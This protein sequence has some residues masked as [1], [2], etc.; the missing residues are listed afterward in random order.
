MGRLLHRVILIRALILWWALSA[1]AWAAV[2]TVTLPG[3]TRAV[4]AA[5]PTGTTTPYISRAT[6]TSAETNAPL[7]FE[8]ALKMR[9]LG[10]LQSRVNRGEHVPPAE[11]AARYQPTAADY[12]A[13]VDWAKAQ[14]FTIVRQDPRHQVLFLRGKVGHIGQ[15]LGVKFSR[16]T[17]EGKEYTSAVDA[18]SVPANIG[19]LLIGINGLQPHL[20]PHR[21]MV[22]QQ[23]HPDA[24]AG[25]TSFLPA[26]IAA[27]YGI[28]PLYN[29]NLT[30]GGQSIAIVIDTFP[31][32]TDL[33]QFW[34]LAS[35]N[36]SISNLI[37]VQAVPGTL[38]SP[39]GEETLD[40][41]WASA[42]APGAKV[43]VYAATSLSNV[44]L[45]QTY[46]A[47]L[48]DA[49]NHPEY[50]LHQMSM[51]FGEGETYATGA[52]LDTDDALFLQLA[53]AGV[54]C[55][56]AS[57]D[58][59][60]TPG[61]SGGGDRSGPTQV[62]SPASDPYVAG[63]G[64]TSL[65]VNP[66]NTISEVVWNNSTGATGG[67]ASAHFARP[68]WQVQASQVGTGT[69]TGTM[70]LVPDIAAA[71]DPDTGAVYFFGG[72]QSVIGGTS[73][74]SPVWAG[75]CALINQARQNAGQPA[76][77]NL[78]PYLYPILNGPDYPANFND[79]QS[80]NNGLRFNSGF[81]AQAGYDEDTGV[82]TPIGSAL[83]QSLIG[84]ASLTGVQMPAP[85]WSAQPGETA[86]FNV[87][88]GGGT[89]TYQ[90]QR[91]AAGSSSWSDLPGIF[92]YSGAGSATL[93]VTNVTAAMNGDQFR[94]NL[95]LGGSVAVT[96]TPGVL[97]VGRPLVISTLAGA[98]GSLGDSNG[99]SPAATFQYPSGVACDALG[100]IYVADFNN[101]QIRKVTPAGVV[102]AP[103]GNVSGAAGSSNGSGNAAK[104]NTPNAVAFDGSGNLYVAD[105]GN[106]LIRKITTA[107]VVSTFAGAGGTTFSLP[108]G[109][110]VDSSGNVYVA[111]TG[112]H[113]IRKITPGGTVSVLAGQAGTS[114]Y[115]DGDATGQALF[116]TPT[117]VAVDS[118]GVVY[119]ADYGNFVVRRIDSGTV[120]TLAGLPRQSG[121]LDG[122]GG[123]ALFNAP[124]GVAVD[125]ALNV[126]VT[127]TLIPPVGSTAAGNSLLRMITPAGIV[128]TLAGDPGNESSADGTGSAA[129]FYSLQ[130]VAMTPG[131]T[132]YFADTYN[133]L[134]RQGVMSAAPT[135]TVT[136]TQP[137]AMVFGP[138][139]GQFT[140]TRSGTTTA[141]LTVTYTAGGT[142]QAGVD[143]TALS[144]SVLIPAGSSTVTVAVDPI[145]DAGVLPPPTVQLVLD[146]NASPGITPFTAGSPSA[147]T[148]SIQEITSYQ[149]WKTATF[150]ASATDPDIG[151]DTADPNA[152][153][154]PNLL[155]YAFGAD[156][157]AANSNPLPV[158]SIVTENGH[159]YLALTFTQI[160]ND[161]NITVTVQVTS[162]LAGRTDTW[163][164]GS[165][166]TTVVS[167]SIAGN[168]TTYTVRDN[169]PL[170]TNIKRFIRLQVTGI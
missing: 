79:V 112:N 7:D 43:R 47:V 39:S 68:A 84:A 65:T 154:V 71:A 63:V 64:G 72:V 160:D 119:V 142:A 105:T 5:M 90:W 149:A 22:P 24:I 168:V 67:G 131:G 132:F 148:V 21:H 34:S 143:Y 127:D 12:Q 121:Y 62:D 26:Q 18:P 135:I 20:H 129:Q 111:D 106:N 163:H 70:R 124:T 75:L 167:S 134:I 36:Q 139:P 89:A 41:E 108:D 104:F 87:A 146:T 138:T 92:P 60:A 59:G 3:S 40:T 137:N 49:T 27:A 4:E 32:T 61:P 96:S 13:V 52:Q 157:L 81:Q 91:L 48:D 15:A 165:S 164:S 83:A 150:A 126:Y 14:G 97:T 158:Q 46:Q 117:G 118:N 114:G 80:G 53:N 58:G 55:F 69:L 156:P 161:S 29:A 115:A 35:I 73:W 85:I 103:Y 144:G 116:N 31:S 102:T 17:F 130:S 11:M 8:I 50:G 19:P 51:S 28:T 66:D 107:G 30:G 95:T 152:N 162:D 98:T 10:E 76:L 120:T 94:C 25:N 82:G 169:T 125:P 37:F 86:I 6:L 45:D 57:G 100:N 141:A 101:N 56:A 110:A 54:T 153:G 170:T 136:A 44:N 1:A 78:G 77:G 122:P 128:S 151:G 145:A 2:G 42:M 147:A 93:T 133:Q 166:A 155:E 140:L 16:V 9:H 99:T 109:V 74:S 123:T 159:D 113:V 88:V 33:R 23:I 38:P